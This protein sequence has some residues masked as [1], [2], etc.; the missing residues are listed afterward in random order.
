MGKLTVIDLFSGC[1]GLSEGFKN[2][3]FKIILANDNWGAVKET[4][5]YNHPKTKL[6]IGDIKKIPS[7]KIMEEAGIRRGDV[8]VVVGGPPCQGFSLS[9]NRVIDDPRNHLVKEFIRVVKDLQPNWFVMENVIGIL[10]LA[11]GEISK[12]IMYSFGKIGYEMRN[13]KILNATHYGVPQLRKRVFYI[14]NRIGVPVKFPIEKNFYINGNGNNHNNQTN[15]LNLPPAVTVGDAISDLPSLNDE[16]GEE[17][18]DYPS[19]PKTEYQ[20]DRRRSS[21]K[22]YNHVRSNHTEQTIKVINLVPEGGNWRDLPKE[23]QNI[24]SFSNTWRRLDSEYPSVT[25]DTGHRHHFHPTA[26]RVPTVRE[27][28]RIQGF[29]DKFRFLSSRTHQFRMVGNA[30]PPLLAKSIAE[31]IKKYSK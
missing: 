13:F 3:K 1:G 20:E 12:E 17:V 22:L 29:D 11:K 24:R 28:A 2:A 7:K 15:L 9:G 30:V 16:S 25:I 18:M 6:I 27:S 4:F 5:E 8:D 19:L 14:G 21:K 31:M 23:Y 10:S 26:N